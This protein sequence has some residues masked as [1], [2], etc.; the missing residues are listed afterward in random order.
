MA[1]EAV[2][3]KYNAVILMSSGTVVE[4]TVNAQGA[5]DITSGM[6]SGAVIHLNQQTANLK[7]ESMFLNPDNV[8]V[9]E[10]HRASPIVQP[11][12]TLIVPK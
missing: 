2:E 10:I 9:L 4:L 7:G 1:V 3:V 5:V 8:A 12:P 6:M 11:K